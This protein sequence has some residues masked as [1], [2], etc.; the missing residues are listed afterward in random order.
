MI[1]PV[2]LCEGGWDITFKPQGN[3]PEWCL[4]IIADTEEAVLELKRHYG[5][6]GRTGQVTR[7][8]DTGRWAWKVYD[9]SALPV[10]DDFYPRLTLWMRKYRWATDMRKV[11]Y[12]KLAKEMAGG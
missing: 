2:E 1:D 4:A 5:S 11:L 8:R 10:I 3:P 9:L 6:V 12:E 7:G